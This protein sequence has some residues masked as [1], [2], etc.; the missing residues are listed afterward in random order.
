[1]IQRHRNHNRKKEP[2]IQQQSATEMQTI[3]TLPAVYANITTETA[4]E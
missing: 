3:T 1:M 2:N 4:N